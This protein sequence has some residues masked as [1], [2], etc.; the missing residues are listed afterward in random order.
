MIN[1]GA[2]KAGSNPEIDMAIEKKKLIDSFLQQELDEKAEWQDVID[3][4]KE[5]L[6]Q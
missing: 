3:R 6:S 2:Y 1:I 5:I 4:M